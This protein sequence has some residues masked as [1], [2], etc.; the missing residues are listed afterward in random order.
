MNIL[1]WLLDMTN[2]ALFVSHPMELAGLVSGA[3]S[4][5]SVLVK[6]LY[7]DA[8][9]HAMD[10]NVWTR[11]WRI[12]VAD[13]CLFFFQ[14]FRTKWCARM[15]P[16][17]AN[18]NPFFQTYRKLEISNVSP[19]IWCC[20]TRYRACFL[21]FCIHWLEGRRSAPHNSMRALSFGNELAENG[22]AY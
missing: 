10:M 16:K 3:M 14:N 7:S 5:C 2:D 4:T 8:T 20:N 18:S 12:E 11:W 17:I 1:L 21:S 6:A 13:M 19:D 9:A 15:C 22:N